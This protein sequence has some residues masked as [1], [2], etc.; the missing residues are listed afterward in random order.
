MAVGLGRAL[1]TARASSGRCGALVVT[2]IIHSCSG[3]SYRIF[4]GKAMRLRYAQ[5]SD[6]WVGRVALCAIARRQQ[7]EVIHG[8]S[9]SEAGTTAYVRMSLNCDCTLLKWVQR[10]CLKEG[11]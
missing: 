3:L 2:P 4:P 8:G 6:Y 10:R 7:S 9:R 5:L 11:R 1:E